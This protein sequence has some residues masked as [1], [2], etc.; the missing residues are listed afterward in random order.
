MAQ[1]LVVHY[2]CDNPTAEHGPRTD[3]HPGV[4]ST[5]TEGILELDLCEACEKVLT[6]A[7]VRII[8]LEFGRPLRER[9]KQ[10]KEAA[11]DWVA[12]Y[13]DD[14]DLSCPAGCKKGHP[15][16]SL[17]GKRMHI[18]LKHAEEYAA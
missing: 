6:Y 13:E 16:A 10:V 2:W 5:D 15:F 4:V 3:A 9:E 8:A 17:Q 11:I 1:E 14:S 7:E 18:S 12:A